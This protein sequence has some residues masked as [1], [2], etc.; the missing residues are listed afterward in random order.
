MFGIRQSNSNRSAPR[1]HRRETATEL[2]TTRGRGARGRP[3]PRTPP[4]TPG[5][6]SVAGQRSAVAVAG[7]D[8][9]ELRGSAAGGGARRAA[10]RGG[11]WGAAGLRFE[12]H[13]LLISTLPCC[14]QERHS[15]VSAGG[16]GPPAGAPYGA[17]RAPGRPA[18]AGISSS[19]GLTRGLC[20]LSLSCAPGVLAELKLHRNPSG[21][22]E[23]RRHPPPPLLFPLLF[24]MSPNN[25]VSA[26]ASAA[27]GLPGAPA[28]SPS[29][30]E[31]PARVRRACGG[32]A[33][34][35]GDR[36]RGRLEAS[37]LLQPGV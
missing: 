36:A 18:G 3:A 22:W 19:P 12:A 25:G 16:G 17:L 24:C 26:R 23:P 13:R 10:A 37:L 4:L 31:P 1:V 7:G 28:R 5:R 2:E 34:P 35:R 27:G 11:A 29:R 15:R 8:G 21:P 30:A 32:R 20:W 6:G 33:F 14:S 9:A